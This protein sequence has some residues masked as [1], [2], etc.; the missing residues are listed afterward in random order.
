MRK[1]KTRMSR[2]GFI[3]AG[4][5][6]SVTSIAAAAEETKATSRAVSIGKSMA[7]PRMKSRV[8]SLN[9]RPE[10]VDIE[11]AETALVV[12]D[13]QNDFAAKGG[14]VDRLGFDI[15][16]IQKAI[17]PIATVWSPCAPRVS[18]SFI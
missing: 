2:R 18:R 1:A 17:G 7:Q 13:M 8:V 11:L 4:A 15:A 10:R 5:V 3:A 9:A 6:T 14:L 16:P 12:V